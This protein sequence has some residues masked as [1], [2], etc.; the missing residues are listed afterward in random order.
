MV[1]SLHAVLVAP[2]ED[3]DKRFKEL[4]APLRTF[5]CEYNAWENADLPIR[6]NRI[7]ETLRYLYQALSMLPGDDSATLDVTHRVVQGIATHREDLKKLSPDALSQ[8][9]ADV[10][11][12]P[13]PGIMFALSV[14]PDVIP[15]VGEGL[16]TEF[17]QLSAGHNTPAPRSNA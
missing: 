17:A 13:T 4:D 11:P 5:L 12:V 9:D 1:E 2:P 15:D 14:D 10:G 7:K 6:V 16:A 8:F 3:R